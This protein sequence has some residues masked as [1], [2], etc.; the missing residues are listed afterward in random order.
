MKSRERA[1]EEISLQTTWGVGFSWRRCGRDMMWKTVPNTS[2]G[3]WKRP[4]ADGWQACASDNP[5]HGP[6][7]SGPA[8]RL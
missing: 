6:W 5:L 7:W 1:A 4:I 3:N 2:C 8:C